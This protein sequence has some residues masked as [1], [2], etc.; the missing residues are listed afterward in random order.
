M[1]GRSCLR[2]VSLFCRLSDRDPAGRPSSNIATLQRQDMGRQRR[3][4][5]VQEEHNILNGVVQ[6]LK[7]NGVWFKVVRQDFLKE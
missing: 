6:K 7:A 5:Q 4:D 1:H 2:P 3:V